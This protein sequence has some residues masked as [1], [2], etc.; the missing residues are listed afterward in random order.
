MSKRKYGKDEKSIMKI[1]SSEGRLQEKTIQR[2]KTILEDF[3]NFV[4]RNGGNFDDLLV[5]T[6]DAKKSLEMAMV[7]YWAKLEITDKKTKEKDIPKAT[8]MNFYVS[9]LKS[10]LGELTSYDFGD[11]K[12]NI[13]FFKK[14]TFR[15]R[16]AGRS[17][18]KKMC[19][20]L[21]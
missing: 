17:N 12:G 15:Y 8:T 13:I 7:N 1:M 19:E 9:N 20:R 6:D 10:A 5:K 3:K 21:I 16:T 4:S 11:K 14:N 2:R 18:K